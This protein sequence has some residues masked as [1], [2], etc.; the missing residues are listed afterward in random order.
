MVNVPNAANMK[1]NKKTKLIYLLILSLFF[2]KNFQSQNV[3]EKN[4]L[5]H[6]TKVLIEGKDKEKILQFLLGLDVN[7]Y[8]QWHPEHKDYKIIKATNDTIGSVFYYKEIIDGFKLNYRWTLTE[9]EH[10]ENKER[11]VMKAKIPISLY[12]ILTLERVD[13]GTLIT[14]HIKAGGKISFINKLIGKFIF[15]PKLIKSIERHANEEFKNL[16]KIL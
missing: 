13:N 3:I 2:C 16:E 6:V 11:I 9:L 1:G 7:Q 4:M 15:T 5:E 12:L 10:L 8:K 14:H